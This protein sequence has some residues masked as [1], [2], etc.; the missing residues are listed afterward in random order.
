MAKSAQ[1]DKAK[2]N[3]ELHIASRDAPSVFKVVMGFFVGIV[4]GVIV[5]AIG[6]EHYWTTDNPPNVAEDRVARAYYTGFVLC[7]LGG[8]LGGFLGIVVVFRPL[9][10][11]RS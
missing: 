7:P 10:R 4:L 2:S 11:L 5:A 8:L 6:A 1:Q 9:K 3:S